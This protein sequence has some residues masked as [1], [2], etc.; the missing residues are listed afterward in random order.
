MSFTIVVDHCCCLRQLLLL[1]TTVIFGFTDV[2]GTTFLL[3]GTTVGFTI[4]VLITCL[5]SGML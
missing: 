3:F 5:C 1:G 4:V 2:H